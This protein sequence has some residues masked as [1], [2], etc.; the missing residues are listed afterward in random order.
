[1]TAF[2][3]ERRMH[4]TSAAAFV[5][6]TALTLSLVG[7]QDQGPPPY[8]QYR[9]AVQPLLAENT[10]LVKHF[11]QL[12]ISLK[13]RTEAAPDPKAIAAQLDSTMLPAAR[14]LSERAEA[15]TLTEASLAPVH[16]HLV[17]A[18]SHRAEAWSNLRDA[19]G[20]DDL[21]AL[22]Q[23]IELSTQSHLLEDQWFDEADAAL[24]TQ[25]LYLVRYPDPA[26]G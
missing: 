2:S 26:G 1:M 3:P 6:I 17:N 12:A 9:D 13:K 8:A 5:G 16:Q 19:Y 15:V 14:S 4:R 18:W 22:D 25:G 24:R 21:Q 23:A 20:K 10:T 7:C 11:E